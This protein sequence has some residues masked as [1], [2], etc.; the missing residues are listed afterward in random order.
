M[1]LER[2]ALIVRS[3]PWQGRSD[4]DALD[5]ALA[6]VTLDIALDLYVVGEGVLQLVAG[7]PP[8]GAGLPRGRKAWASLGEFG[9]VTWNVDAERA[10]ALSG[11]GATWLLEARRLPV[12]EMPALQAAAQRVLVA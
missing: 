3:A 5:L 10:A 1:A 6:A 4:R 7:E 2:L 12:A 9:E 11:A 8:D